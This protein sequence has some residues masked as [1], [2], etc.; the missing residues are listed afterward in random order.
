MEERRHEDPDKRDELD[1]EDTGREQR[2]REAIDR[3][4]EERKDLLAPPHD[5][6]GQSDTPP[7]SG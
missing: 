4:L 3:I 1:W 7:S 2:R 6:E 5:P